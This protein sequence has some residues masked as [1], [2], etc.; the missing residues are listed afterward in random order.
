MPQASRCRVTPLIT[1]AL[2]FHAALLLCIGGGGIARAQ[3]STA[4]NYQGRVSEAGLP[5][6][7][8]FDF[9]FRLFDAA[10]GGGSSAPSFCWAS[11]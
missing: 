8:S 5:S 7:G 2:P 11:P 1:S 3:S 9:Q 6:S 4:F 10:D